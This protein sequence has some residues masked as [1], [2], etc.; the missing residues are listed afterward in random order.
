MYFYND[1]GRRIV[2]YYFCSHRGRTVKAKGNIVS[3]PTDL[4][5]GRQD[6]IFFFF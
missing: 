3:C 1:R 6:A 2:M 4:Q 5:K